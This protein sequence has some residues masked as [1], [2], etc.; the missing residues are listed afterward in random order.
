MAQDK[1]EYGWMD[2]DS[3]RVWADGYQPVTGNLVYV[4]RPI[5]DWSPVPGYGEDAILGSAS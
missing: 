2:P 3:R 4:R 1:W 5:A